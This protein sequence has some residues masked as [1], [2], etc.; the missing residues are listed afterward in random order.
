MRWLGVQVLQDSQDLMYLQHIVHPDGSSSVDEIQSEPSTEY[1]QTKGSKLV[2][3]SVHPQYLF[4]AGESSRTVP[5]LFSHLHWAREGNFDLHSHP[6]VALSFLSWLQVHDFSS[7]LGMAFL[8][9]CLRM[10]H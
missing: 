1:Q 10:S 3:D 8:Q 2:Q 9:I 6:G 7:L 5:M 4:A